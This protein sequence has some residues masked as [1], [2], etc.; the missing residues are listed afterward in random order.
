M[1]GRHP[2]P[3]AVKEAQ[4]N[5][6]HRPIA[7]DPA[8]LSPVLTAPQAALPFAR[9][10]EDARHAYDIIGADLRRLNFVRSTDE[11]LLLRYCDALA[12]FW[13][14]TGELDVLGG[15]TY[16]TS[17]AHGNMLRMRPQ[18]MVQERLARRL[19]SM[20]DRLGLSPMARQQYLVRMAAAG[21]QPGFWPDRSAD[22]AKDAPSPAIAPRAASPVGLLKG[23]HALN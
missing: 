16:E 1:R 19:E 23:P 5:P 20:E 3:G 13:R 6:G 17:S 15:E 4:G 8:A 2:K 10:S 14:V 18:F 22:D 7:P 9:L 11:P 21:A 12:R